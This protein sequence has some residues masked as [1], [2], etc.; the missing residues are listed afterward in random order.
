MKT[1]KSQIKLGES[2]MVL[3][4][5]IIIFVFGLYFYSKMQASDVSSSSQLLSEEEALS[6]SQRITYL[7]E[8][9][10]TAFNVTDILCIDKYK[11]MAFK[12]MN[13]DI[14]SS[15]KNYYSNILPTTTINITEIYPNLTPIVYSIY[16]SSAGL[17]SE[18]QTVFIPVTLYN[19]TSGTYNMA[20]IRVVFSP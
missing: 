15:A 14:T 12:E 13:E 10:C 16:S 4:V 18:Y 11:L 17:R 20:I 9:Q 3:I 6:V 19:A 1:K 5:F 7:P 8:I 2:V